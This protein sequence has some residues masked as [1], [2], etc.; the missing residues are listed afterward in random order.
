[1]VDLRH[2][3]GINGYGNNRW[4]V[5]VSDPK[6]TYLVRSISPIQLCLTTNLIQ[7]GL[8]SPIGTRFPMCHTYIP[9][10]F[11]DIDRSLITFN[12]QLPVELHSINSD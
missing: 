7:D 12:D 9:F 1:M 8:D 4:Q 2:I 11:A 6:S 10:T 3:Q 5:I